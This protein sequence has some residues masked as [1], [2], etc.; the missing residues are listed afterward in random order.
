[1]LAVL[2]G[3]DARSDIYAD[4]TRDGATDNQ[5]RASSIPYGSTY[6]DVHGSADCTD[7]C[8]GHDAGYQWAEDNDVSDE[9]ECDGDS[10]SFNEGCRAYADDNSD[11]ADDDE[12]NGD[13]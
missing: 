9:S 8:S 12:P 3:C 4:E 13:E 2:T 6:E 10:E 1:M 5:S 7:D 11:D